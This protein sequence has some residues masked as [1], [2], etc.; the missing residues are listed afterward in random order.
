MRITPSP[1]QSLRG[2]IGR[3]THGMFGICSAHNFERCGGSQTTAEVYIF[4][5]GEGFPCN[6]THGMQ[7]KFIR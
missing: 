2:K 3:M 4:L 5:L 1:A 6:V 7:I